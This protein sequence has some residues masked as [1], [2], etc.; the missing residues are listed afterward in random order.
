MGVSNWGCLIQ[1]A[2]L[3]GIIVLSLVLLLVMV[4]ERG[5]P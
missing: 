5:T 1:G 2:V 4:A 3:L